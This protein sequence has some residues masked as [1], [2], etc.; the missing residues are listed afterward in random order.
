MDDQGR[1]EMKFAVPTL[2]RNE[3][4]RRAEPHMKPDPK[5]HRLDNL[6]PVQNAWGYAVHSLYFDTPEL[7]DY[8]ERLQERKVRNRLRIRTYGSPEGPS[9]IFLENKRK[10][11]NRVVKQRVRIC[12]SHQWRQTQSERPW[13]PWVDR[14]DEQSRYAGRHFSW[15]IN[16]GRRQPVSIVHYLREVYIPRAPTSGR[17]RFTL[18]HQ[19][20]VTKNPSLRD[21]KAPSDHLL[22]PNDWMVMELKYDRYP[23]RWMLELCRDLKL[24]SE[25]IS[26]FGM[27]VAQ[28][29][30]AHQRHE[31][32]YLTPR[33]LRPIIQAPRHTT[34]VE[35]PP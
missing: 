34:L 1:F 8:F 14:L 18:D 25:P 31:V 12:D 26:K 5:A 20:S 27:S 10:L 11:D 22:I 13:E 6:L 35:S 7:D 4:I 16:T 21:L 3:L 17:L 32:R 19:V 24:V 15:L 29:L 2:L 9:P 28:T 23:H 33:S 30:R